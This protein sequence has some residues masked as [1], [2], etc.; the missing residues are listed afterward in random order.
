MLTIR[1]QLHAPGLIDKI[2]ARQKAIIQSMTKTERSD[3][4]LINGSRRKR[5]AAGAGVEV[6][7][8]NKLL[9]MHRQMADM[10]KKMGKSRRMP[11]MACMGGRTP[12]G[13]TSGM[14]SGPR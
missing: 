8:V 7:G 13:V 6:S 9:K 2:P 1:N 10:M 12:G 3:P 11:M 5:I 4:D 14:V